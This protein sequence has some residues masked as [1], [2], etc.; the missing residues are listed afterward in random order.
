M[1]D[2]NI[3]M[4]NNMCKMMEE[5]TDSQIYGKSFSSVQLPERIAHVFT[6]GVTENHNTTQ[7]TYNKRTNSSQMNNVEDRGGSR[8][9]N[10][11]QSQVY[12]RI[13]R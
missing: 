4:V 2:E 7:N 6:E 12:I 8:Q 3:K 13:W 5:I 10:D 9:T 1:F 11:I